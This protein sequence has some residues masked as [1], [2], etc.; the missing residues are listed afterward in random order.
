MNYFDE[1]YLGAWEFPIFIGRARRKEYGWFFVFNFIVGVIISVVDFLVF[2]DSYGFFSLIYA[3]IVFIPGL[4]LLVRRVHD[5]GKS[6][7]F[8]LVMIFAPFISFVIAGFLGE[9]SL[10]DLFIIIGLA[11]LVYFIFLPIFKKG[12]EGENAYGSDP[13]ALNL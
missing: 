2:G 12:D 3:L 5:F 10:A 13:K 9:S 6:G 8:V 11:L 4:A 7:Q 1:Y